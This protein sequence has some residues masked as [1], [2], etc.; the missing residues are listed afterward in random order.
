MAVL[1]I[2]VISLL[3]IFITP[4]YAADP[5]FA[6]QPFRNKWLVQDR[7]VG[8][9]GGR[10]YTWGPSVPG[11]K[12]IQQEDY[13]ESPNG[14][15][16]VQYFD[17]ARMELNDPANGYVTA[18]LLVVELISGQ[19]QNGDNSVAQRQPAQTNVAGDPL[20]INPGT[21][22][23]VSFAK[24]ATL[25]S[26][27]GN[28]KSQLSGTT[29][30]EMLDDSGN[31]TSIQPPAQLDLAAYDDVTGHNVARVFQEFRYQRGPIT[32]PATNATLNNQP[33]YTDNP[34][35]NVFGYAITEPYWVKTKIAGTDQMVLVQLFQRRVLTYNPNISNPAQRVEMGNVGQHY[36]VWRY[37][38]S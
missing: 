27:D 37:E 32:D 30:K 17:K 29:V 36:Y 15:R 3:N 28:S 11:G 26:R 2:T 7:L 16:Q 12:D 35:A 20:S 34:I 18:G 23:Y 13:S 25:G 38:L 33:V 19:E 8:L 4:A 24:V 22:T 9:P 14:K 5:N 6:N 31:V 1:L 10:P 21:P